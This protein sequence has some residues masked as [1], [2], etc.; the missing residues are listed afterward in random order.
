MEIEIEMPGSPDVAPCNLASEFADLPPIDMS[1][2]E[3]QV[4]CPAIKGL[5]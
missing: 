5:S 2:A 1:V 3:S 4:A